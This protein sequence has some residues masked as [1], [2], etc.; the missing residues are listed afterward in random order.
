MTELLCW[1]FLASSVLGVWLL[2]VW[3]KKST[4]AERESQ[5]IDWHEGSLPD[6]FFDPRTLDSPKVCKSELL[7]VRNNKC[8]ARNE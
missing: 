3:V 8:E 7:R 4:K 6:S 2:W 5:A 1:A